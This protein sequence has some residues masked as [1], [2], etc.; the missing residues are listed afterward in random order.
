MGLTGRSSPWTCYLF[1]RKVA[2]FGLAVESEL[3]AERWKKNGNPRQ[4]LEQLL[5]DPNINPGDR[6]TMTL[7]QV[8]AL[9]GP[10]ASVKVVP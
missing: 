1:D 6:Q 2:L 8:I 5:T 10:D 9:A 3:E 4:R 7:E